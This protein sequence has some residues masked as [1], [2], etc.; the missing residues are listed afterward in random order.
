MGAKL[1]D[2]ASLPAAAPVFVVLG[3]VWFQYSSNR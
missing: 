1:T 2:Y 3:K